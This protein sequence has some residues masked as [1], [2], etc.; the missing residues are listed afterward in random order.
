M[1]KD[2]ADLPS[3]FANYGIMSLLGPAL[4]VTSVDIEIIV[5]GITDV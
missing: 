3:A 5:L 4:Q 2:Y 1:S